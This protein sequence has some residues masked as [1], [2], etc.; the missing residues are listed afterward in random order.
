MCIRDRPDPQAA[1]AIVF[2]LGKFHQFFAGKTVAQT[3]VREFFVLAAAFDGAAA[4]PYGL[5]TAYA[6]AAF[7]KITAV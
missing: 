5:F 6:A 2:I 4:C 3:A 1:V 7:F